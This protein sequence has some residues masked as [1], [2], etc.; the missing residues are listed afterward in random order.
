MPADAPKPTAAERK[1]I[2]RAITSRG[3]LLGMI[4]AFLGIALLMLVAWVIF[5][6]DFDTIAAFATGAIGG[7]GGR[8]TY[9]R[10]KG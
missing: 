2:L 9:N 1:T 6:V 4:I 5:K 8:R 3:W 7:E 10:L